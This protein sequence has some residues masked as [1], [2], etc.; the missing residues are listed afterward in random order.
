MI[1]IEQ[2]I[3]RDDLRGGEEFITMKNYQI[4]KTRLANLKN[5]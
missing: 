5:L 2:K 4:S 1:E 3:K